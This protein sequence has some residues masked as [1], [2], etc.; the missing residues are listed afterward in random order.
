MLL[1]TKPQATNLYKVLE[2]GVNRK[3]AYNVKDMIMDINGD[4]LKF[5]LP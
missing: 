4:I 5:S 3:F 1:N 2:V